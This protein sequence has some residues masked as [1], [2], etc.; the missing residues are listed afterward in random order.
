[1]QIIP[2]ID[3]MEG[4][5]VRLTQG[6][7]E[8]KVIYSSHPV[9]VA[10][11]WEAMGAQRLHIV[12]LDGAFS[13]RPQNSNAIQDIRT[14][15]SMKIEVGGGVRTPDDIRKYLDMEIDHVILGTRA[16]QDRKWLKEQVDLFKDR[17]IVGLDAKGGMVASQGWTV[18]ETMP[19]TDFARELVT[20]GVE[21]IIYTDIARDGMLTGP[22]LSSL[23]RIAETID[24]DIIA[25]GGIHAIGDIEKII[26][27]Q[28]PNITG[29]IT[30][31]ALYEKT[32]DLKEAIKL[33][34]KQ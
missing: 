8:S 6:K 14:A 9:E 2:A 17:I 24:I 1:M 18:T 15:V 25:S 7:K 34:S 16:F 20:I 30:G 23:S 12:D 21:S 26:A 31:K 4:Q 3:L 29:V 28:K 10:L 5:C 32:L 33:T 27:L 13:G 19:A 11:K 22:N